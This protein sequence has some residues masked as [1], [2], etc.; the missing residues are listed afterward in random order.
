MIEE[1]GGDFLQWLRGFYYAANT[2]SATRV[3]TKMGRNQSTISHQIK[4]LETELGVSLFDR[5]SGRMDLTPEG[6]A[7]LAKAVSLFELIKEMKSDV[8]E[9]K[10]EQ[11]GDVA[12]ATTHAIVH[13]FLPKFLADFRGHYPEVRF[14]IEGGGLEMILEKVESAEADFGIASVEAVPDSMLYHELFETEVMLI[15]P[16]NTFP[17]GRTPTLKQISSVPFIFFPPSSTISPFIKR[18]FSEKKLKLNVVLIL[19]NFQTVKRYV[20]TGLGISI[21][22]AYTLSKEDEAH[23]DLFPLRQYFDNRRYGLIFRKRKYL[24]AAAKAFVRS[25]KPDIDFKA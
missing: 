10:L 5:S 1:I 24:S 23:I 18:K 19:N 11:E 21:L 17:H 7:L 20:A 2:R 25:I 15:T 13:F 16:K 9:R 14:N 3:A 12:I 4:C 22:D 6:K 8:S